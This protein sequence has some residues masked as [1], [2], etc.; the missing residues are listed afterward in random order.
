MRLYNL[1]DDCQTET[2]AADK[3]RLQWLKYLSTVF[4]VHSHAG[5]TEAYPH[6]RADNVETNGQ[7]SALGHGSQSVIPKIPEPLLNPIG[8]HGN[9]HGTRSELFVNA[10]FTVH[11]RMAFQQG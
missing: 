11:G 7:R 1:I 4:G 8:I 5:I 3:A 6:E 9:A 2:G 10:E